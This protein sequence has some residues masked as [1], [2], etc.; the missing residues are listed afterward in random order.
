MSEF[1]NGLFYL[2]LAAIVGNTIYKVVQALT[3][4]SKTRPALRAELEEM[5]QQLRNQTTDLADAHAALANQDAQL[6]ELQERVDFAERLL[7]Q[8]AGPAAARHGAIAAGMT[9]TVRLAPQPR[10]PGIP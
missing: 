8:G 5:R 4:A 7:A 2:L 10:L 9:E 3:G 6:Q 1:L